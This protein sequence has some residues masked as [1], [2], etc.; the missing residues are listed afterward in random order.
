MV[1]SYAL[2]G[3]GQINT[4][5]HKSRL[6]TPDIFN[7]NI[8]SLKITFVSKNIRAFKLGECFNNVSTLSFVKDV[9]LKRHIKIVHEKKKPYRCSYCVYKTSTGF[10]L[11]VHVKRVHERRP[12]KEICPFCYQP[13]IALEWHI[14]TYHAEVATD[15]L[16]TSIDEATV[17]NIINVMDVEDIV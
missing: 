6:C 10:N 12:L 14:K 8:T 9:N 7:K 13:C 17:N 1:S 3:S 15:L 5:L 2:C 16:R 11:R 4:S